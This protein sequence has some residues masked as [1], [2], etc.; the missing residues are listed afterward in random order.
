MNPGLR[1]TLGRLLGPE[2]V[3]PMS[4]ELALGV[5]TGL[6]K[7]AEV[8]R[9]DLQPGDTLVVTVATRMQ[10]EQWMK[11]T[12]AIKKWHPEVHVLVLPPGARTEV[13]RNA[14]AA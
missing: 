9:L 7:V 2:G 13:V 10:P 11:A 8:Q 14:E 12:D 1:P 6:V 4:K 3:G 5:G